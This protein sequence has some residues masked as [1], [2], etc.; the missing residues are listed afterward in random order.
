M[1]KEALPIRKY[2]SHIAVNL[3]LHTDHINNVIKDLNS[4]VFSFNYVNPLQRANN[5]ID[6]KVGQINSLTDRDI[7][8]IKSI[9]W[10]QIGVEV[11]SQLFDFALFEIKNRLRAFLNDVEVKEPSIALGAIQARAV[12][13]AVRK[14]L[15]AANQVES[16]VRNI[17]SLFGA[18]IP[19]G[20]PTQQQLI[21][22]NRAFKYLFNPPVRS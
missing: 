17:G 7:Q 20:V 1:F 19:D 2:L 14:S 15:Q 6:L 18:D 8:Y 21:S 5:I 16:G 22:G 10:D 9:N 3:N 4:D 12:G 11:G 13:L